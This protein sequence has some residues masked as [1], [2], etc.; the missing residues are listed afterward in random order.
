MWARI[1]CVYQYMYACRCL[2]FERELRK[3]DRGGQC[4]DDGAADEKGWSTEVPPSVKGRWTGRR[5]GRCLGRASE[6]CVTP[7]SIIVIVDASG[8][9]DEGEGEGEDA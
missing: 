5:K 9:E 2:H 7:F 6:A 3:A 1:E 8:G 4:D